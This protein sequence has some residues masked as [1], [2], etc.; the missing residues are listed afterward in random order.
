MILELGSDL[1]K[2]VELWGFEPQT[3]C[4][5][6]TL[7]TSLGV[8]GRRLV[9]RSPAASVAGRGLASPGVAPRWLPT[10]LPEL[11]SAANVRRSR[12]PPPCGA[13][14]I[15]GTRTA[16]SAGG[17]ADTGGLPGGSDGDEAGVIPAASA[18]AC[19]SPGSEVRMS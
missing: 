14:L 4:M 3:S 5:P 15:A 19:R 18:R 12:H 13:D 17:R 7:Q 11:V 10:W 8:A 2:R 9:W 6:C 1:G 16:G